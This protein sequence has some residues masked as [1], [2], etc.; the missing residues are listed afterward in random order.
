M[1]HDR[2][3]IVQHKSDIPRI[4]TFLFALAGFIA[5]ITLTA[6]FAPDIQALLGN[7]TRVENNRT[8]LTR[9]WTQED[10]SLDE[11][12]SMVTIMQDNGIGRVYAETHVWHG[13][14]R[15]LIELPYS[16]NFAERFRNST[17]SI[18]LYV[19]LTVDFSRV[20]ADESR[21]QLVS[22]AENVVRE[23][24]Y[25]GI[26]LQARSIP[27]NSEDFVSLLRDLRAAIGPQT[28]LSITVPPDRIPADPD[29]PATPNVPDDLNWSQ[30]YK[31]RIALNV[32]EMVLMSHASGLNT[33]S[34]YEQWV[35]Y[36]VA[37]YAEIISELQIEMTF[38]I[39]LPTYEREI[40][41]DPEVENVTS[42]LNG[43]FAGITRARDAGDEIDYVGLYPWEQTD[44]FELDAYWEEWVN[45]SQASR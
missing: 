36:Q 10:R 7:Q 23:Q 37:T 1:K 17:G 26:H 38:V 15:E 18:E 27:D 8:W 19:W 44:L 13:E 34:D 31:R 9:E 32:D 42:A 43:V 3:H 35:A 30:D 39:A 12:Q 22:I 11:V 41:Y 20:V 4:V 25:S 21:A 2:G 40:G 24:N 28:P 5:L 33:I 6:L 45:Q 29:V 14:S 16:R